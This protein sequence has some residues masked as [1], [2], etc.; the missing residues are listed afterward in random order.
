MA[1]GGYAAPASPEVRSG[2]PTEMSWQLRPWQAGGDRETS[3]RGPRRGHR[4]AAVYAG[5]MIS[6]TIGPGPERVI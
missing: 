5:A 3:G 4:P 2:S 6:E 1:S